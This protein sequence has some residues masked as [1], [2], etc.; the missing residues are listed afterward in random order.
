MGS[1]HRLPSAPQDE[2]FFGK[3]GDA[4]VSLGKWLINT[5]SEAFGGDPVY[6]SGSSG[7]TTPTDGIETVTVTAEKLPQPSTGWYLGL[8]VDY[9]SA[10]RGA[11]LGNGLYIP[12]LLP[13]GIP[14]NMRWSRAQ[15]LLGDSRV[16]A[17]LATIRDKESGSQ[18]N[19]INGGSHFADYSAHPNVYN[20]AT[21]STAAGAY[22]F[23]HST[24][25]AESK[26]LG[27]PDFSPPAQDLAAVDLLSSLGA[28]NKL[29]SG[30]VDGA[31]FCGSKELGCFSN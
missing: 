16:Q 7:N 13:N 5:G 31:I 25:E 26:A 15:T 9:R 19:L 28:I 27:L 3:L 29:L 18:Y 17:L 21:D 11:N 23:I 1:E 6:P 4:L 20:P 10:N 24:W 30:D 2:G 22:Q 14:T 8:G 12:P